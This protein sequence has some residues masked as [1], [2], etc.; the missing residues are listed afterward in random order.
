MVTKPK[1]PRDAN[2]L[3]KIIVDISTGEA[4]PDPKPVKKEAVSLLIGLK[5][6]SKR[7]KKSAIVRRKKI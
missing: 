6:G 4:L 7:T 1:R 2:Q 3:A 5:V